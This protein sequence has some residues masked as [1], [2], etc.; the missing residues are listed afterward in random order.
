[1]IVLCHSPVEQNDHAECGQ[2]RLPQNLSAAACDAA[3]I[4]N[5][6]TTMTACSAGL[7][8]R[9]GDLRYH[10][11]NGIRAPQTPSPWGIMVDSVDPLTGKKVASSI[12]VWTHVNDLW[13]QSVVDTARYIKGELTTADITDGTYVRDW[14][15]AAEAAAKQGMLPTY[16][17]EQHDQALASLVG[18]KDMKSIKAL[19]G[20]MAGNQTLMNQ[21]S[22]QFNIFKT[23]SASVNATSSMKPIYEARRQRALGSD[24]EAALTTQMMQQFGGGAGVTD[25]ATLQMLSSPLRGA[26]PSAMRD[27]NQAQQMA[28]ANRG[29]CLMDSE[30]PAPLAI[31]NL[32]NTFENKFGPFNPLAAHEDQLA[33]A[34][35]IRLYIAHRAH[36]AVITHEM[37]HSIG[38]R[39]NFVS[40]SDAFNYRPQYWA[41]RTSA[42]TVTTP[43]TTL[44]TG[45]TP[46]ANCVGP[47]YYDPVTDEES[48]N[49]IEMWMQSSTMDYAGETTQDQLGLGAYDFAAARMFYGDVVSVFADPT[50][51]VG[52]K[53]AASALNKMD[54]F[55]GLLGFQPVIGDGKGGTTQIHY[56][57]LQSQFGMINS[58]T[59]VD[60]TKF[61]PDSWDTANKGTWD[62]LFDGLIVSVGGQPTRCKQQPVDY[63]NWN[64]M[65]TDHCGAGQQ[66]AQRQTTS[67]RRSAFAFRTASRRTPGR[68]SATSP[69]TVTTTALTRTSSSTSSS[70]SR[71]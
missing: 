48:N 52:S 60:V 30:A 36:Y 12:N 61:Q 62:P 70:R 11:I 13:S 59:A 58:C 42:G 68:T 49:L 35:A 21:L 54:N 17:V 53:Q 1:M 69:C 28:F 14:A 8:V 65:S 32:A 22:N 29:A 6:R 19:Q 37:G 71:K 45:T 50:F 44:G 40:S 56:S 27:M 63:V 9:R 2:P 10:Q 41:L 57:Q 46:G 18:A 7:T 39:H 51:T 20:Q 5:D 55:G 31:A 66:H 3:T 16:T 26:N 24:T 33:H 34:E 64:R 4:A 67:T 15:S 23:Y 38:L 47:R 43:C 25:P